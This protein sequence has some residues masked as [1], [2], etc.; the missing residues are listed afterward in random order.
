LI[1]TTVV[2]LPMAGNCMMNQLDSLFTYCHIFSNRSKAGESDA[3][4][5]RLAIGYDA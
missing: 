3:H 2:L 4:V 5:A 1:A